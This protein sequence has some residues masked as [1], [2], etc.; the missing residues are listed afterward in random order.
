MSISKSLFPGA[1]VINNHPFSGFKKQKFIYVVL[2]IRS[3]YLRC[4]LGCAFSE[5]SRGIPLLITLLFWLVLPRFDY[6]LATLSWPAM[7]SSRHLLL[8]CLCQFSLCLSHK[9][10]CCWIM[11]SLD[12]PEMNFSIN[13][14]NYIANNLFLNNTTFKDSG[15][16]DMEIPF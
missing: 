6:L 5:V 2:E 1:A 7:P 15:N 8:F 16:W 9:D 4:L 13:Q 11:S 3:P 10:S 12:N 14:N